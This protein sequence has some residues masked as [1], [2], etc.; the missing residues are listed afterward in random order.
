M[1]GNV[2]GRLAFQLLITLKALASPTAFGATGI[3]LDSSGHVLL[4]RHRYM[5]GWQLP[6]GGVDRGEP[7]QAAVLRELREEVG[8]SG[9]AVTF[10]GL[11]TR[12]A[13]WATN[14]IALYRI[15]GASVDFRP[16]L[17]IR[18][19]CFADPSA[20]PSGCSPATLRRLAELRGEP[21]SPRW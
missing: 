9:G 4:V 14:V 1:L 17:E 6:G 13:G 5:P 7:P 21:V 19:I 12:P 2:A 11:Y 10:A 20:P 15:T 3:V 18:E 16:S 8:L